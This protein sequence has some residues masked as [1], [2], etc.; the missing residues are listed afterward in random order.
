M[1][2]DPG[3][4]VGMRGRQRH[5]AHATHTVQISTDPTADAPGDGSERPVRRSARHAAT[6]AR[7]RRRRRRV[8]LVIVVV[9]M[10][11]M[12]SYLS[13]LSGP[14]SDSLSAR[15]V[16]WM[17]EHHL[18]GVVDT[19]ERRWYDHHQAKVGG[20]PNVSTATPQL[21]VTAATSSTTASTTQRP[22]TSNTAR[23]VTTTSPAATAATTSSTAAAASAT[24]SLPAPP[25]LTTPAGVALAGEGQWN[26]I[27]QTS[28]GQPGT[29]ATL[30][31][32]D[33]VHTSILDA[34]VWIDP[35]LV[36]LR[37]YPGAKLPGAPWDRPDHIEANNQTRLVAAFNGGFRLAD[38]HGGMIL[39]G[40]TIAP[41]RDGAA[42]LLIDPNGIPTIGQWGR[43]ITAD[44]PMDSARQNLDLIVDNGAPV[45][46]LLTDP[47]RRWGF[48]GP[49]N[50][51][52]VWRSGAGITADGALVWVGGP[53][54]TV[55]TLAETLVRAGAIR[56]MQLDINQDWVQLNTYSNGA[57]GQVTGTKIL[58][59]MRHTG[60]RWLTE[61]SRDFTAVYARNS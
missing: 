42:T 20:T 59:A 48:T 53:G 2:D 23:P 47:N 18:G 9:L 49:A 38:S 61:D 52:A 10:P 17:R 19:V 14:G 56:G 15:S 6:V 12:Y 57:A 35:H 55:E 4:R 26:P 40:Q 29:Y 7:R 3:L 11:I 39:G 32:P 54:L 46:N 30:I 45:P 28:A 16:E 37:A 36:S 5:T 33:D 31:R 27:D 25:A 34:V 50:K 51:S 58:S 13:A 43:D 21:A 8:L 60:N 1:I 44:Q 41:I 24:N 22:T